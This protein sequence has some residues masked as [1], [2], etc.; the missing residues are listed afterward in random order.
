[1]PRQFAPAARSAAHAA[2]AF[3]GPLSAPARGRRAGGGLPLRGQ[4]S[5]MSASWPATRS[6]VFSSGLED[7]AFTQYLAGGDGRTEAQWAHTGM[8]RLRGTPAS[9]WHSEAHLGGTA[10]RQ[11]AGQRGRRE[12]ASGGAPGAQPAGAGARGNKESSGPLPA[13]PSWRE[14]PP[15]GGGP[16]LVPQQVQQ[17]R[18]QRG[19]EEGDV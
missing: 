11:S 13:G 3:G 2:A 14:P 4:R 19:L 12:G 5:P 8:L 10:R 1:M 17:V 9:G 16:S 15:A 18:V 6:R 7:S